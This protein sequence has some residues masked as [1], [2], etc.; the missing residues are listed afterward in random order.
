VY[1]TEPAAVPLQYFQVII[2]NIIAGAV[3]LP[4]LYIAYRQMQERSGR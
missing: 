2:P 1:Q 4:V 3:L